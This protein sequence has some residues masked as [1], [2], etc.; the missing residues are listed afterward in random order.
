MAERAEWKTFSQALCRRSHTHHHTYKACQHTSLSPSA[1]VLNNPCCPDEWWQVTGWKPAS[2]PLQVS[3][4]HFIQYHSISGIAAQPKEWC[5][6]EV[7]VVVVGGLRWNSSVLL[8]ND[9]LRWVW[10]W[11][12]GARCLSVCCLKHN[13]ITFFDYLKKVRFKKSTSTATTKITL[14]N[15]NDVVTPWFNLRNFGEEQ[16]YLFSW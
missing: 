14:R 9:E 12:F 5:V 16:K 8:T 2:T 7:V 3:L 6:K 11:R 4:Q 13:K 10:L 15:N 1:I